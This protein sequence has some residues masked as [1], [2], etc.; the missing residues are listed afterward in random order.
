MWPLSA[1]IFFADILFA[2]ILT[3]FAKVMGD[4]WVSATQIWNGGIT[5]GRVAQTGWSNWIVIGMVA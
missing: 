5:Q 4:L 1:S 3:S 2:D